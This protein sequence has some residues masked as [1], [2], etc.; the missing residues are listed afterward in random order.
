MLVGLCW[1]GGKLWH[2]YNFRVA[3]PGSFM[4]GASKPLGS[5]RRRGFERWIHSR[6]VGSPYRPLMTS[7]QMAA[8]KVETQYAAQDL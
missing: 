3:R 1:A 5:K 4:H 2:I 6:Q 7:D 8:R